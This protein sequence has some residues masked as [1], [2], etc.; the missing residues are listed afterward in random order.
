MKHFHF[1]VK[2]K[3]KKCCIYFHH[4]LLLEVIRQEEAKLK[5]IVA[6]YTS[7]REICADNSR[8]GI[9][10][11][12]CETVE[13]EKDKPNDLFD[14][15]AE[16]CLVQNLKT[17]SEIRERL[18]KRLGERIYD[19][20]A[21]N[22]EHAV[23]YILTG[24]SESNQANSRSCCA[25]CFTVIVGDLKEVGLKVAMI[26]AL[27]SSMAGS[28]TRY[29]Y[30]RLMIAGVA[31]RN[32]SIGINGTCSNRLGENIIRQANEVLDK[33]S[34]IPRFSEI[35][36]SEQIIGEIKASFNNPFI[37]RV[38]EM[39]AWEAICDTFLLSMCMSISV[40]SMFVMKKIV[41]VYVPLYN[42]LKKGELIRMIFVRL[43]AGYTSIPIG[44]L[45]GFVG[46]AYKSPPALYF[47]LFTFIGSLFV[48][49]VLAILAGKLYDCCFKHCVLKY[50]KSC[51]C[52]CTDTHQDKTDD[53]E[54]SSSSNTEDN[55]KTNE[56]PDPSTCN[57]R[58][59]C[60][61]K[62]CAG[63]FLVIMLYIGCVLGIFLPIYKFSD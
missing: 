14:F 22:C 41:L 20:R 57:N 55:N 1:K 42:I 6:H 25:D 39:L 26:V 47:F 12:I 3:K 48:R 9:G 58:C 17:H 2:R 54:R 7:S 31:A 5:V 15:E 36:S 18:Y 45:C 61:S 13:V 34:H 63:Y 8:F 19:F 59:C 62:K 24:K 4:F 10:K 32:S 21:N 43:I 56:T 28:L 30:V 11:F 53:I 35:I 44:V 51:K 46:Q 38:S 27:I 33:H 50:C 23:N 52:C 60:T 37:C 16:L 40:E 49:Y 29:S